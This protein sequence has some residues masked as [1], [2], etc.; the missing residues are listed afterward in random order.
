MGGVVGVRVILLMKKCNYNKV[1][2][3]FLILRRKVVGL[4]Q[5]VGNEV[6]AFLHPIAIR[7]AFLDCLSRALAFVLLIDST[8]PKLSDEQTFSNLNFVHDFSIHL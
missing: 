7:F 5:S 1:F 3:T 2:Y 8:N 4:S 6:S